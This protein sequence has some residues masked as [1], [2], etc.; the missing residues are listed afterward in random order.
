VLRGLAH[1]TPL[2]TLDLQRVGGA[3]VLCDAHGTL[4][5]GSPSGLRLLERAGAEARVPDELWR[6]LVSRPTGTAV[7]WRARRDAT[8][9]LG[10]TRYAVEPEG[11]LLVMSE[12]SQKHMQLVRRMNQHRL[13]ALGSLVAATAHDLRSPLASIFFNSELLAERV[14]GLSHE[15]LTE[16]AEDLREAATRLRT[17]IDCLLDFVRIGPPMACVVSVHAA[18]VRT[19]SLLRPL[20]RGEERQIVVEANDAPDEVVGNPLA[21]EQIFLNLFVNAV[22]AG[23]STVRAS[24]THV[25]NTLRVLVEDDGH[26]IDADHQPH[27]FDPFFTTKSDGAGIGLTVAREVARAARGDLELV[28]CQPGA[29]FA[30]VLPLAQD[31]TS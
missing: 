30:L 22:E 17:T 15:R 10:C 26:G 9:I 27:V 2:P 13:E 24:R 18:L 21:L 6:M 14:S 25:G 29:A 8:L 19:H 3:I 4:T 20:L 23:A 12:I 11:W 16:V 1:D 5:S 31:A 28:R 7:Q